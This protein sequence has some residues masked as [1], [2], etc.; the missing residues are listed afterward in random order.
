M[1]LK[2]YFNTGTF[3]DILLEEIEFCDLIFGIKTKEN[4]NTTIDEL[5]HIEYY[6]NL[7]TLMG[8]KA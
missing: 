2:N 3:Y 6:T 4:L 8:D 1:F 5:R 7:Y